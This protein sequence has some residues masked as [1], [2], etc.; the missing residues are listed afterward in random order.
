[1]SQTCSQIHLALT[2]PC[3]PPSRLVPP[4]YF[5]RWPRPILSHPTG[6]EGYGSIPLGVL[7]SLCPAGVDW[8]ALL[9][10]GTLRG[11]GRQGL[12]WD[13]HRLAKSKQEMGRASLETR[14]D[15]QAL[16][17]TRD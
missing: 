8:R 14:G 17:G 6:L 15:R 11:W 4:R 9:V 3:T 5:D 10:L 7:A 13:G 16:G 2:L 12:H 1:M